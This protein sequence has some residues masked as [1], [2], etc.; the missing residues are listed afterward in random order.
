MMKVQSS[1][2]LL[3]A[4][5]TLAPAGYGQN[6]NDRTPR[7]S[8]EGG[9]WLNSLTK[10]YKPGYVPPVDISN[11]SRLDQ[12]IRAGNLYLSLDDAI[13]L[14]LENNIDIE[15]SRYTFQLTDVAY[16]ASLAG[17]NGQ[18]DPTF[19]V[20]AFNW[21]RN[22]N[23]QTNQVTAGGQAVNISNTRNRNFGLSQG[24]KTGGNLTFGFTNSSRTTNNANDF[25]GPNLT[26]GLS[27]Q[28]SQPLLNGFGLA[29][30]TRGIRV[31]KNN[32][33]NSDYVFQQQ[34]NNTINTV[35]Q[36]YWNLV[37]ASLN[38]DVTKQSLAQAEKLLSDNRKQVEIGTMAPI[39]AVQSEA[40]VANA[41]QT[42]I[43]AET[44]VLTQETALKNL[45]SRN[46]IASSSL[47][48]VHI[49]PTDRVRIPDVE[50]VQPVQDL[51]EMAIQNRPDLA[52]QRISMENTR[53]NMAQ[54][55]NSMLPTLNLTGNISNPATGGPI[56][57][58]PDVNPLTG[59]V[60]PRD[61]SRI[62]PD[63]IGG[64]SNILRQL[65]GV[66]TLSYSFG[67]TLTVP[68][69]NRTAQAAFVTQELQLRQTELQL[70]R[71]INQVR[72]DVQNALI[73]ITQARARF[74]AVQRQ[75][76]YQ[77]QILDAEQKKLEL[78]AS[79]VFQVIQFQN[80]LA[81]ARQNE[82]AAQVAYANA[83]LALDNS[84]GN[85]MDRYGIVF[86]EAKDGTVTR[87][88]DPIPA[89]LNTPAQR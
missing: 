29:L 33:R 21:G 81:S 76:V 17:P 35:V 49:I 11:S 42:V 19:N 86:Q 25:F 65:F 64:Y 15:V 38:V 39:E 20:N 27:L 48:S 61:L 2:A 52:Q 1:L 88:P 3:C 56:N 40:N 44:T 16:N 23:I 83:K 43:G 67:F 74:N 31:A 84:T 63:Y 47:S 12:I 51:T 9:G 50:P 80:Q 85:L 78:G 28:G 30:N 32:Q 73:N 57:P 77:I 58:V 46:G 6:R 24:F 36:A 45:L 66:P 53:I 55:K 5:L 8:T 10:K 34:V 82:V 71:A 54:T 4:L 18:W 13:S 60:R 87:R 70:Q 59:E 22:Q 26:S 89:V 7:L 75:T 79:T 68:L 41:E 62:N 69:R 72:A 37:S 14:A